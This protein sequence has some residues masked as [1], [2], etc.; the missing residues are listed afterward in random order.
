MTQMT[1]PFYN[2]PEQT[3]RWMDEWRVPG[4]AVAVI[5]RGRPVYLQGFGQRD[6]S[7]RLPVT[8]HTVF[9]IASASKAFTSLAAGMLVDEGRLDWDT[10]LRQALPGFAMSDPPASEQASLRDL[11]CH[12]TGL[13][14][15]DLVTYHLNAPAPDEGK[16]D[17]L[18]RPCSRADLLGALRFL[19]HSRPFRSAFQYTNLGYIAAGC[20]VGQVAEGD[21]ETGWERFMQRRIF[22]PLGMTR[23]RCGL[24]GGPGEDD[25]IPYLWQNGAFG[26]MPLPPAGAAPD[27]T[28]P[29]GSICS[30]VTD[31]AAWLELHLGGGQGAT[32]GLVSEAVRREMHTP[33]IA[34]ACEAGLDAIAAYPEVGGLSY[35]LGWYIWNY[36]GR[37]MVFH[38]GELD[39]FKSALS[40]LPDEGLGVAILANCHRT[41]LGWLLT[42]N[43]YDRLLGLPEL[44]WAERLQAHFR[45]PE[46]PEA[47]RRPAA[48]DPQVETQNLASLPSLAGQY[49]HPAYGCITISLQDGRLAFQYRDLRLA[50]IPQDGD[51]YTLYYAPYDVHLPVHFQRD[52]AGAICALAAPLEPSV[53]PIVFRAGGGPCL[54]AAANRPL[55]TV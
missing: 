20:L 22:A 47:A 21:L 3:R 29:A 30:C 43:L 12:R 10:P 27:P 1:D 5:A 15:H 39:G 37:K 19:E 26:E 14:R 18:D 53:A 38:G 9:P 7:R 46:R 35:G 33:Q 42:Y 17:P 49:R 2:F 48:G 11:L 6:I 44:P 24:S 16:G 28:A 32:P 54:P 41:V 55:I 51:N 13:P 36:R 40:F 8:P 4:V 23:S 50:L 34:I 45:P 31:L 25:A 52:A